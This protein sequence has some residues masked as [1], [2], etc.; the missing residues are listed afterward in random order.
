VPALTC[1]RPALRQ[2]TQAFQPGLPRHLPARRPQLESQGRRGRAGRRH[3]QQPVSHRPAQAAVTQLPGRL[4]LHLRGLVGAAIGRAGAG[5]AN[6]WLFAQTQQGQGRYDKDRGWTCTFSAMV[7]SR[8]PRTCSMSAMRASTG[9]GRTL[10]QLTTDHRVHVGGGQSYLG[11][12]LGIGPQ[13]E[14]DYRTVALEVGRHLRAG[15]RRRACATSGRRGAWPLIESHAR[16]PRRRARAI[17]DAALQAGSDDNLTVQVVRVDALPAARSARGASAGRRAAACARTAPR[18]DLRRL[19]GRARVARRQPQPRLPGGR[20]GQPPARGAEGAVG[21]GARR[22]GAPRALPARGVGGAAR[23]QPAPAAAVGGGAAAQRLY[24]AM[25]YVEG[26]TLTQWM[27]DHPRPPLEQVRE[28]VE[29]LGRGLRALHR[30][31]CCTR[32]CGPRT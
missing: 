20:R 29:Q 32:T 16:R 11:R 6:S 25:E 9:A 23:R 10:E 27:A 19:G 7:P 14:I 8:A 18:H 1:R 15:H 4:L 12:A 5:A 30:G 13:V 28:I 21:R 2:G 3:Q 26:R 31:R 17:A 24:V 22:P